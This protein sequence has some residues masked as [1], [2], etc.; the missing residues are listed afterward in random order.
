MPAMQART[1]NPRMRELHSAKRKL[2]YSDACGASCHT[3]ALRAAFS[4]PKKRREHTHV[5]TR[6]RRGLHIKD[7]D[8]Q[9]A[10]R[11][12]VCGFPP[13]LTPATSTSL[14]E[15]GQRQSPW[16]LHSLYW[17]RL[18]TSPSGSDGACHA[19]PENLHNAQAAFPELRTQCIPSRLQHAGNALHL[20]PQ[21][22]QCTCNIY[23]NVLFSLIAGA[24]FPCPAGPEHSRKPA[25]PH[26]RAQTRRV[27]MCGSPFP[28]PGGGRVRIGPSWRA[29][30]RF[31]DLPIEQ[32]SYPTR[33]HCARDGSCPRPP[34]GPRADNAHT[35]HDH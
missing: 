14:E 22:L 20:N 31:G 34:R 15:D 7:T 33:G 5:P 30:V 3:A 13:S 19:A 17:H 6:P 24:V 25:I 21:C 16:V 23:G 26:W 9:G 1:T 11:G 35:I 29:P 10:Q 32:G 2:P 28:R 18:S 12:K 4:D 27:L 8:R